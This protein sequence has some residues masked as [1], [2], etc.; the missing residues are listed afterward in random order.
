VQSG[1][2]ENVPA[3]KLIVLFPVPLLVIVAEQVELFTTLVAPLALPTHVMRPAALRLLT[4]PAVDLT[5]GLKPSP[6]KQ[7]IGNKKNKINNFDFIF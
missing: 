4:S 3:G 7:K 1:A 5:I 6:E 2:P